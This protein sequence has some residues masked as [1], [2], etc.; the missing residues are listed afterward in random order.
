MTVYFIYDIIF[1]LFIL[2]IPVI[3]DR[4]LVEQKPLV[5]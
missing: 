5:V 4:N 2:L 1:R 3:K